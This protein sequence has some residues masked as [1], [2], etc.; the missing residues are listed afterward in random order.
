M[1]EEER[2]RK[3]THVH[4][5]HRASRSL[6]LGRLWLLQ[7]LLMPVLEQLGSSAALTPAEIVLSLL[8]QES[9]SASGEETIYFP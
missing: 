8:G 9:C 3:P 1:V 4:D 6:T 2:C 7:S 5:A